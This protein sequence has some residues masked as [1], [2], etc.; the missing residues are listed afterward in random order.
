MIDKIIKE[1]YTRLNKRPRCL[2]L[3]PT[4][5]LATQVLHE[6]KQISHF[7]KVSSVAV[8]GGEE[9]NLQKKAVSTNVEMF[10]AVI[11]EWIYGQA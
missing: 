2:I 3:V 1:G 5:E 10:C 9:Y 4:R 8:L 7:I 11:S 6:V